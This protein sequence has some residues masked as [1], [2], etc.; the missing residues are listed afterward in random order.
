MRL[1]SAEAAPRDRRQWPSKGQL[2]STH[3]LPQSLPEPAIENPRW[4]YIS[5]VAGPGCPHSLPC[6]SSLMPR[7]VPR[8][9]RKQ[10][11]LQ[12]QHVISKPQRRGCE[13]P[14]HPTSPALKCT[15]GEP[16]I[17]WVRI[18]K[19]LNSE[20]QRGWATCLRPHS[21]R[22]RNS[23]WEQ[24]AAEPQQGRNYSWDESK[25]NNHIYRYVCVRR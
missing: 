1:I 21:E 4:L 25:N 14:M 7:P 19:L 10:G 6:V 22:I 13:S 12:S 3:A 11:P 24:T 5:A 16:S 8:E 18:N 9:S 17:P 2:H 15:L 23:F 20:A